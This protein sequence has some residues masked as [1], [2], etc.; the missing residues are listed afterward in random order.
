MAIK[1][2]SVSFLAIIFYL[3][4]SAWIPVFSA[5]IRTEPI[6]AYVLLETSAAMG[7][8]VPDAADWICDKVIDGILIPGD[9][10][11]VWSFSAGAARL[12]DRQTFIQQDKENI[13]AGIR[14]LA[15]DNK[16][17]KLALALTELLQETRRW[18]SPGKT[19]FLVVAGSLVES[20]SHETEMLLKR[21]K[22]TDF[23]GWKAVVV[24]V[25]I[26]GKV[27]ESTKAYFEAIGT[28]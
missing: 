24:G 22:V 6:E 2:Y 23:P 14:G 10:L 9:R 17:P 11:S 28:P 26:D 7:N 4:S 21:S 27:T 3:F 5:D 15:A 20:D 25:G 8:A 1:R 19:T 16:A 12:I 18:A 13:K